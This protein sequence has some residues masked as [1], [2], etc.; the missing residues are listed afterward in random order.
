MQ[1]P[2]NVRVAIVFTCAF[3]LALIIAACTNPGQP[4]TT[5]GGKHKLAFVT[6]NASDF[7]AIGNQHNDGDQWYVKPLHPNAVAWLQGL[8]PQKLAQHMDQLGVP[9]PERDESVR[10]LM[11][12][13]QR[14]GRGA[15][16]RGAAMNAPF[17]NTRLFRAPPA[18]AFIQSGRSD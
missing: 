12:T 9:K 8:D 11:A 3:I 17:L 18:P 6:N 4:G 13:K 14:V 2:K 10:R 15:I 7:W 5:S 16:S 1:T